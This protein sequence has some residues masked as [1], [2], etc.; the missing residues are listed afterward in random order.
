MQAVLFSEYNA[1]QEMQHSIL[2]QYRTDCQLLLEE[3]ASA[4]D[5]RATIRIL[6]RSWHG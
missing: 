4:E 5:W 6:R 2:E 1:V 3:G